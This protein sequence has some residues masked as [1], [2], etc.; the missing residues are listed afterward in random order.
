MGNRNLVGIVTVTYNSGEVIDDFMKSI[1]RQTYIDFNLYIIDNASSDDTLKRVQDYS[2]PR[3]V[4]VPN[5]VNSG[6]AEGNN[7]G[8]RAALNDGCPL[9]LLINNDT[10]FDADLL[11]ELIAGLR[12]HT[13][14]M[15]VPKILFFD[16]PDTIWYAGGYFNVWRGC[17]NHFGLGDKDIGQFD[18]TK[19]VSYSPTCC[20]LIMREVFDR[21]GLMDSNYFLYFDDTD[22]CLRASK[23]GMMLFYLSTVRIWHKVSSL[24]GGTS[25]FALRYITRNHVY[26]VLKHFSPMRALLYL[27]AFYI[28]LPGKYLFLL[29]RPESFWVTQQAFWE[30]ISVFVSNCERPRST[31]EPTRIP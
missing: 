28:Y 11:E 16:Q 21:V 18:L 23:A 29:G 20:M 27:I 14:D 30:G 7:I 22:F 6:V 1:L 15:V 19:A 31:P 4:I 25:N 2:D 9:V 13:C 8:I 10:V 3:I 5:Q 12:K 17:G 24:T 26:Y